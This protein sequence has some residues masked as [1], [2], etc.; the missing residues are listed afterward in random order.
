MNEVVVV[1]ACRTAQGRFGG[2]LRDVPAHHLA[3]HVIRESVRRSGIDPKHIDG[4]VMG[5][6]YQSSEAMNI[7]RY[8]ALEADLPFS[9]NSYSVNAACC[10]A[11]EAVNCAARDIMIGEAEVLIGA[12]VENMSA[13]PYRVTGHRWGTRRGHSE[14]IDQFEESTWTVS[15]ERFG[16]FNMGMAGDRIA[17]EYAISREAQDEYA[18][19]SQQYALQS[20]DRGHFKAEVVPINATTRSGPVEFAVDETPRRDMSRES[21]AQ[22]EPAFQRGGTVTAGNASKV[23]DGAAAVLLMSRRKADQLGMDAL[24]TIRSMARVGVDPR[25]L[26]MSPAPAANLALT[27]AKLRPEEIGWWEIN[28]AFASVVIAS[29]QE[30][31]IGLDRVNLAGGAIAL[32]HPVGSSGCRAL[33]TMVHAMR[34]EGIRYGCCTIGGG[35]GIATAAVLER[36]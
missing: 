1:E 26:C 2:T 31:G 5:Q 20:I 12:G 18:L 9:A 4:V 24:A 10:S 35:G 28:E 17:S 11:L 36:C 6:V 30:I 14:I 25:L 33:V 21:L 32:G 15:T 13:A 8:C 27:R 29:V 22:L 3:T 23:G 16:P 19:R 7:A 34:R